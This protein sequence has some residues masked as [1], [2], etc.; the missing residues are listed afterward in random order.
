MDGD[1]V[2]VN[3]PW[4]EFVAVDKAQVQPDAAPLDP[5]RI[6]SVGLVYS[7]FDF[8]GAANPNYKPGNHPRVAGAAVAASV[9]LCGGAQRTPEPDTVH[10]RRVPFCAPPPRC[11]NI[12]LF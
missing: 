4:H 10:G 9:W 3:V 5:G 12:Y 2:T 8:N 6:S 1:W 11:R 7:R